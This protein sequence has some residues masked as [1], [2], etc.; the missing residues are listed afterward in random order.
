MLLSDELPFEFS[1]VRKVTS[2]IYG[3]LF[4]I[5]FAEDVREGCDAFRADG[6]RE[7]ASKLSIQR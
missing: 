2:V 4:Q 1:C 5:P 6:Y 3:S 7:T